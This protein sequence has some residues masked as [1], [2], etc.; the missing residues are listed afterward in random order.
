MS[1]KWKV[2]L[3]F[4]AIAFAM[5]GCVTTTPAPAAQ[6]SSGVAPAG[7]AEPMKQATS[8]DDPLVGGARMANK[9]EDP[10]AVGGDPNEVICKTSPSTG[11]RIRRDRICM[12]RAQW[13][14]HDQQVRRG[15]DELQKDKSWGP[16]P[17]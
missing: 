15:V 13:R 8:V 16:T 14:E 12:T 2:A 5:S 3:I 10:T 7:S 9:Y 17:Q 4:G 1:N 6:A 11:S